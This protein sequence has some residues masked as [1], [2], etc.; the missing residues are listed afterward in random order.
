MYLITLV[1]YVCVRVCMYIQRTY[2]YDSASCYNSTSCVYTATFFTQSAIQIS[3]DYHSLT[4]VRMSRHTDFQENMTENQVKLERVI[5][6]TL[7]TVKA[8]VHLN[9]SEG[10]ISGYGGYLEQ[11]M[12]F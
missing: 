6:R 12:N 11:A 2:M 3:M 1:C 4:S 10:H 7:C 9:W 5:R 8:W